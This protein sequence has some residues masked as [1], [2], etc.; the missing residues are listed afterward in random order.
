MTDV[1]LGSVL[2]GLAAQA[3]LSPG[4]VAFIGNIFSLFAP[5]YFG[6]QVIHTTGYSEAAVDPTGDASNFKFNIAGHYRFNGNSE[7]I[8]M[9]NVGRGNT[10]L[11]GAARYKMLNFG[12]QQHKLEY[13]TKNFTARAYKTIESSGNTFQF[14]AMGAYLFAS[15]P[16]GP[17]AFGTAFLNILS[18][19]SWS[20]PPKSSNCN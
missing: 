17:A 2:P 4:N 6:S 14:D 7:L 9:S 15:Q 16:G 5:N 13:R 1:F 10:I 18:S 20:N 19:F 12:I 8:F 11:Q 3:G